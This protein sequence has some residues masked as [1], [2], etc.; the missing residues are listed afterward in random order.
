VCR[1]EENDGIIK[2][3]LTVIFSEMLLNRGKYGA[4]VNIPNKKG[5]NPAPDYHWR[6]FSRLSINNSV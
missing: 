3:R 2:N 6:N 1:I 5:H 4:A